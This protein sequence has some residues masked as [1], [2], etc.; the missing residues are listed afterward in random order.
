PALRVHRHQPEGALQAGGAVLQPTG[1]GGAVDKRGQECGEVDQAVVPAV[2]RKSGA[3]AT[4]C[5]GVQTGPLPSAGGTA[6]ARPKMESPD[7]GGEACQDRGQ[8]GPSFQVR[9]LSTGGSRCAA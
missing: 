4:V 8:G 1:Y 3:I 6:E 7:A 5:P 2:Q 9:D